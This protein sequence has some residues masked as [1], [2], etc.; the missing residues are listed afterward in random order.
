MS[1]AGVGS[2]LVIA[3]PE[4]LRRSEAGQ[5]WVA[6]HSDQPL[7]SHLSRSGG[8]LGGSPLIIPQNAGANHLALAV[9]HGHAMHLASYPHGGHLRTADPGLFKH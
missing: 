4:D 9:E 1:H 3:D 7:G 6:G 2:R 8:A 5:H